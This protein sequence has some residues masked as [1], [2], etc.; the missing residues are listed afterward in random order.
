MIK[1][2]TQDKLVVLFLFVFAARGGGGG[3]PRHW[4]LIRVARIRGTLIFF[5][6]FYN[7]LGKSAFC[8]FLLFLAASNCRQE[9]AYVI[10]PILI[11]FKRKT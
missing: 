3:G 1:Y 6:F 4:L 9:S 8:W 2:G 11:K 10:R 7:V 5:F